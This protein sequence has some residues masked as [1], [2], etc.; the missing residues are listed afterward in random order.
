MAQLV[1]TPPTKS[2]VVGSAPT[3]DF[4]IV[5]LFRHSFCRVLATCPNQRRRLRLSLENVGPEICNFAFN[6]IPRRQSNKTETR[7]KNIFYGAPTRK[8]WGKD[9][10]SIQCYI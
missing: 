6:Y 9:Y 3:R 2:K 1:V 4:G 8:W 7:K 10:V 5:F